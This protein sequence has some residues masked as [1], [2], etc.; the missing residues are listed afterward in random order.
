VTIVLYGA[1]GYT[2]R[3]VTDE[4]ARRGLDRVLS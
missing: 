3:L 1:T 2:G 4:L